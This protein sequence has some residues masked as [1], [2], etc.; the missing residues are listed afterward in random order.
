MTA[1]C[2][3][4]MVNFLTFNLSKASIFLGTPLGMASYYLIS[5]AFGPNLGMAVHKYKL[6]VKPRLCI[7]IKG[8]ILIN[9][10]ILILSS[11]S[12]YRFK[13][14]L[15]IELFNCRRY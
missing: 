11:K 5:V 13:I 7:Y 12:N 15:L 14:K 3:M 8:F 2:L 9:G 4:P 6:V 10:K 1:E